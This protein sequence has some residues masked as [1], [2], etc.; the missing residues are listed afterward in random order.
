[1]DLGKR[2]GALK[3][4]SKV[5][6]D[7]KLQIRPQKLPGFHQENTFSATRKAE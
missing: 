2:I 1:M 4:Q 6:K 3:F 7:L 5:E